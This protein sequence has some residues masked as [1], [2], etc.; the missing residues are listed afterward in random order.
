[1]TD[2]IYLKIV[3]WTL[4]LTID[5]CVLIFVLCYYYMRRKE[6]KNQLI[7]PNLKSPYNFPLLKQE[8]VQPLPP[9]TFKVEKKQIM[10]VYYKG[11][12][13]Y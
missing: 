10:H 12:K 13:L 4:L 8:D 6:L 5:I 9:E 3:G 1:M 11:K 2:A 7:I